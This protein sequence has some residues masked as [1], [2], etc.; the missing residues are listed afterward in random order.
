MSELNCQF[1]A[2]VAHSSNIGDHL[3]RI[4]RGRNK[5]TSPGS[6]GREKRKVAEWATFLYLRYRLS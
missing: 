4:L 2:L 6:P 3:Y 5:V 1:I